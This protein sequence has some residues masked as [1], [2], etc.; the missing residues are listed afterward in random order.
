[1]SLYYIEEK[2]EMELS[3]VANAI[4]EAG[5]NVGAL[6]VRQALNEINRLKLALSDIAG[7]YDDNLPASRNSMAMYDAS[8]VAKEALTHNVSS[9]P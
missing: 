2:D 4:D 6:R 1:M 7:M 8:C 5:F 3:D 9:A